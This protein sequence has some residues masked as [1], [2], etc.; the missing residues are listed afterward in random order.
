[1]TANVGTLD[2]ILRAILGV[3]LILA[4]FVSGAAIFDGALTWVS[5]IVGA[6]MLFTAATRFCL[7]YQVFGIKTCRT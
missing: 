5:V 4:P 2:R 1:M 7:L 3:V 6:V